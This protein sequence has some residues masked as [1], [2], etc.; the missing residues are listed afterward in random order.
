[1]S[2]EGGGRQE[3]PHRSPEALAGRSHLRSQ[4][5]KY[6]EYVKCHMYT[7]HPSPVLTADGAEH[8]SQVGTPCLF[9]KVNNLE[10]PGV[11]GVGSALGTRLCSWHCVSPRAAALVLLPRR[12][13]GL[14]ACRLLLK[15]DWKSKSLGPERSKS[16]S[17]NR[18][19]LLKISIHRDERSCVYKSN[20]AT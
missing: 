19:E 2:G 4:E 6:R 12:G 18:G 8:L 20:G 11:A 3:P 16:D 15:C 17:G 7:G 5:W 9:E 1:M 13:P 10:R 14:A